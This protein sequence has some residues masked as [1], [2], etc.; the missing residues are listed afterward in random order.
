MAQFFSLFL[1]ALALVFGFAGT[2]HAYRSALVIEAESGVVLHAEHP[3]LR[4][5]PASI[6]KMM[7]LYLTFEAIE[8]GRLSLDEFL[9]VSEHAA[10]QTGQS[11]NLRPGGRIKARD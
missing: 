1:L 4:S 5:F 8:D 3:N 6:T 2:S 9:P 10:G 11:L 7:T